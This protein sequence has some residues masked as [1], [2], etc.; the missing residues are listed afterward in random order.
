MIKVLKA[1]CISIIALCVIFIAISSMMFDSSALD[2]NEAMIL[3]GVFA[4]V[5]VLFV[6]GY[7][8]CRRIEKTNEEW[9]ELGKKYTSITKYPPDQEKKQKKASQ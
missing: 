6:I 8:T 2:L 7:L 9:M 1:I 4:L 3:Y 5:G